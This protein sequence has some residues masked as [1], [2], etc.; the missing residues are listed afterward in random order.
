[1]IQTFGWGVSLGSEQEFNPR[2]L[3]ARFGDGYGQRTGDGINNIGES[4]PVMIKADETTANAALA[5]LAARGGY[6]AFYWTPPI[7]GAAQILVVCKQWRRRPPAAGWHR[8]SA[9]FEKVYE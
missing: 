5:F 1:M 8:I 2:V 7:T 3:E 6:E 4:W 9:T